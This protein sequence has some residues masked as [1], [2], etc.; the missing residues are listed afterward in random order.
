MTPTTDQIPLLLFDGQHPAG[1]EVW[2]IEL[3]LPPREASPNHHVHWRYKTGASGR[4]SEYRRECA[5]IIRNA[6]LPPLKAPVVLNLE[7]Y[8]ARP[9]VEAAEHLYRYRPRK[10]VWEFKHAICRDEDNAR[11]SA[12]P[13]Q[14]AFIDAGIVA[15]KGDGKRYVKSGFC[16]LYTTAK[17]HRG[18]TCLIMTVQ[19]ER[20]EERV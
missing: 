3:P 12:K 8:Y 10:K 5:E 7:F 2:Q 19:G 15:G 20:M 13:A 1:Q 11:S 4:V 9:S 14:D 17:E 16:W 6:G 18:R